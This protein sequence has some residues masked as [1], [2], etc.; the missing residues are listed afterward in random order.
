MCVFMC[1]VCVW[2]L[3]LLFIF[4]FFYYK[5]LISLWFV[6]YTL[7]IFFSCVLFSIFYLQLNFMYYFE[8]CFCFTLNSTSCSTCFTFFFCLLNISF[9][10][11]FTFLALLY[12]AQ[13]VKL[14]EEKDKYQVNG[15]EKGEMISR[16]RQNW[17]H[18]FQTFY[19]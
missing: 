2:V 11:L 14:I 17:G 6:T 4:F 13:W 18:T 10:F 5:L 3:F 8:W 12:S 1:I 7:T 16:W 15:G 19:R 9:I